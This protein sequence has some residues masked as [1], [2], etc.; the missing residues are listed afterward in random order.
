[1]HLSAL[2]PSW[3]FY[4]VLQSYFPQFDCSVRL[5][6]FC[7]A[8]MLPTSSIQSDY[9]HYFPQL[10]Q[11]DWKRAFHTTVHH[12]TQCQA[13]HLLL[14]VEHQEEKCRKA[15]QAV[16]LKASSPASASYVR[17]HNNACFRAC[18]VRL[19]CTSQ[20]C[21]EECTCTEISY[22][23]SCVAQTIYPVLGTS[24]TI[25]PNITLFQLLRK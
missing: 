11:V 23:L 16:L 5:A 14:C 20:R 2:Y 8:L 17:K 15:L 4:C 3:V 1:M 12:P 6:K 22:F 25:F 24:Y 21:E 10:G 19:W 7:W 9:S 18:A 13:P